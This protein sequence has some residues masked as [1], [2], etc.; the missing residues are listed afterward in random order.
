MLVTKKVGNPEKHMQTTKHLES[1]YEID[2]N[3]NNI[4]KGFISVCEK[5]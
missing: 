5:V 4:F 1:L 3:M 2:E